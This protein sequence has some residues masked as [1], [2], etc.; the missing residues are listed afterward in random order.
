MLHKGLLSDDDLRAFIQ[1]HIETGIVPELI[2]S[3]DEF[4]QT[5]N[6]VTPSTARETRVPALFKQL[7]EYCT[8]PQAK[9]LEH[10]RE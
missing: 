8:R 6:C 10:R 3:S 7:L 9:V 1:Q 2:L 5:M 4:M